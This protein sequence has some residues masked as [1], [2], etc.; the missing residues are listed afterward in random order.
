MLDKGKH[1]DLFAARLRS[2]SVNGLNF[3]GPVPLY[4]TTNRGSLNGKHFKILAQITP[5]CL[6]GLVTDTFMDAWYLIGR[7][8]RLTWQPII[9]DIDIYAVRL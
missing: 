4:I 6:H 2:I 5:F 8:A 1:F 3:G 7:L 9:K